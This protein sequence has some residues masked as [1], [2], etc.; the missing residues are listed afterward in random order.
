MGGVFKAASPIPPTYLEQKRAE[1][2]IQYKEEMA[3]MEA[4][5]PMLDKMLEDERQAMMSEGAGSLIG[6]IEAI[7]GAPKKP[8]GSPAGA[9][10]PAAGAAAPAAV[11]AKSA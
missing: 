3:Y 6:A 9:S 1:A 11:A 4:N 2:Q 7:T 8:D 10:A 5:K